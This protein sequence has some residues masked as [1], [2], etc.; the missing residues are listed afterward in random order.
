MLQTLGGFKG[1][2]ALDLEEAQLKLEEG[3]FGIGDIRR[4]AGRFMSAAGGGEK[5]RHVFRG[6]K[7]GK[8]MGIREVRL[9][10]KQTQGGTLDETEQAMVD[11][12]LE[13][14]RSGQAA[15]V[16]GGAEGLFAAGAGVTDEA[17]KNQALIQN[18]QFAIGNA[19]ITTMH[20]LER[21]TLAIN[22]GFTTLAA[23][24]L[25]ALTGQIRD[26]SEEI[27][28]ATLMI[29]RMIAGGGGGIAGMIESTAAE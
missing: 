10:Q 28:K 16:G 15:A 18:R 21:S 19:M 14:A 2:S 17:T 26:F 12:A 11:S 20:N 27:P 8:G 7:M 6:T 3:G 23:G 22:K 24:P 25:T 29:R 4:L 13:R 1:G 9:L 5:G